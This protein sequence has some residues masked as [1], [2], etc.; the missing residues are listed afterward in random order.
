MGLFLTIAILF[1]TALLSV[2]VWQIGW[3]S[4]QQKRAHLRQRVTVFGGCALALFIFI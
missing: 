1:T 2:A 3:H 4:S